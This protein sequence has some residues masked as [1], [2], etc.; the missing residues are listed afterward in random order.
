[1][2]TLNVDAFRARFPSLPKFVYLNSG[3]YG[4]LAD[5]VA[6]AFRDYL[7][8]RISYGA[9]WGAWVGEL[10]AVRACMARLLEV[11]A[12]EVAITGSASAGL[13][14]LASALD[15]GSGRDTVVVTDADFPTGAQIWH[16]QAPSGVKVVHV[17]E[18]EAGLITAEAV[19][20][21]INDRTALVALSHVCYRHGARLSDETI[22]EIC[23][24]A[25]AR[26]AL[27]LLDSYQIV[28]TARIAPR[29]LGVDVLVGGMLKY[30]LGTGGIGFLYVRGA[31]IE[32]LRPRTSGWFAQ[33][34]I[35]AMDI[36]RNDPS[37]TARRFEGGTPPVPSL[38]P[39]RAG[40][41]LVLEIG[42][43]AIE[44]QVRQV[45]RYAL[46]QLR[47]AGIPYGNPDRD[48]HRGPLVSVPARDEGALVAALA[49]RGIVTSNRDGRV[50]AGF[51]A[52]NNH[53]DADALVAALVDHRDLVQA[54]KLV[55]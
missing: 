6:D 21:R 23:D 43:E 25:H 7:E 12:D 39:A 55:A 3:S 11:D 18:N 33:A 9:D 46:N 29:E 31:L 32:R 10:E 15:F 51:H 2:L 20:E 28:G 35:N 1:M 52:Y 53:A 54:V 14:S 24:V 16:A 37:P 47:A 22:R 44:A 45:T 36:F 26:G 30:L 17:P 50:R 42:I 8:L 5:T 27:V 41:E 49:S 4:L 34:D 13:N 38:A 19:V 40:I 48:E